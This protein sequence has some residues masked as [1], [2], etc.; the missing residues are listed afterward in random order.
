MGKYFV[1]FMVVICI[2]TVQLGSA[3]AAPALPCAHTSNEQMMSMHSVNDNH[4]MNMSDSTSDCCEHE[5]ACAMGV[6]TLAMA[7][8]ASHQAAPINAAL[9]INS[10]SFGNADIVLPQ[11]KRP[12]QP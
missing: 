6:L 5:C 10:L 2:L 8:D 7:I 9:R 1:Q 11:P 12:P 4:E 3:F